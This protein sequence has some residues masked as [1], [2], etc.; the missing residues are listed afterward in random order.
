ML[1]MCC[2][3]QFLLPF[4]DKSHHHFIHKVAKRLNMLPKGT[5]VVSLLDTFLRCPFEA[6]YVPFWK[7]PTSLPYP[8]SSS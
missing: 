8:F 4:Q 2:F 5:E 7:F 1:P 6:G 3:I